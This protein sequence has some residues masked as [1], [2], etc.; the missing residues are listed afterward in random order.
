MIPGGE[1]RSKWQ[2]N[3]MKLAEKNGNE[4]AAS[5]RILATDPSKMKEGE[6]LADKKNRND[7][8]KDRTAAIFSNGIG[9]MNKI[10]RSFPTELQ[11]RSAAAS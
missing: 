11:H 4:I 1:V 9:R 2:I 3:Y 8:R 5:C 6:E 10:Q 7:A